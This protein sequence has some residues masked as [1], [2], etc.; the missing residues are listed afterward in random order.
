M[1]LTT[2]YLINRLPSSLLGNKTPFELLFHK[3][4]SYD[5][6]K[7]FG[8]ECFASTIAATRTKFDPKSKWC[9]FIGYPFNVKGYK[10][11]DLISIQFSFQGMSFSM[12]QFF[13]I[14][15]LILVTLLIHFHLMN[16]LYPCLVLPLSLLMMFLQYLHLIPPFLVRF[17]LIWMTLF[18]KF[19]M[20]LMMIFYMMF[21]LNLLSP[22]L[23]LFPLDNP[24][25]LTKS[26][27]IFNITIV[28]W[29]LHLPLSLFFN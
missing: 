19:I 20:S 2:A 24:L 16:L 13:L 17:S 1:G 10:V 26:L 25:E 14:K 28:T 11:F 8:C 3:P 18:F 4:P 15:L 29:L 12:N 7:V 22:L 27:P 5:R 6:L 23:I 21:R 9:V